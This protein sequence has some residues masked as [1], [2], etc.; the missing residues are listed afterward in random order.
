M[1]LENF[2]SRWF[3]YINSLPREVNNYILLNI[4]R[5]NEKKII[6]AVCQLKQNLIKFVNLSTSRN[7]IQRTH[8]SAPSSK[9]IPILKLI[10]SECISHI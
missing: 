5:E 8:K 7:A 6:V 9:P 10:K 1:P 3:K 4:Y 2:G